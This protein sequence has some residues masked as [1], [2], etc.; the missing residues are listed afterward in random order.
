M[1]MSKLGMSKL[2]R[3]KLGRSKLGSRLTAGGHVSG[4]VEGS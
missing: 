1:G 3:S 2:G 4:A